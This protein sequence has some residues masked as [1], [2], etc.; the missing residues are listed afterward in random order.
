MFALVVLFNHFILLLNAY[1][2]KVDAVLPL[3]KLWCNH[4]DTGGISFKQREY[5]LV[6]K[7]NK[8]PVLPSTFGLD[9]SFNRW[10]GGGSTLQM[11]RL[12][13]S[14]QP[15]SLRSMMS[16]DRN[17]GEPTLINLEIH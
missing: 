8:D 3:G 2:D 12:P 6:E 16:F 11:S 7:Y 17:L 4:K 5:K 10:K 15:L 9:G 13:Q 1:F 14:F